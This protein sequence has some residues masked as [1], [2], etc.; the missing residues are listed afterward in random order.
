MNATQLRSKRIVLPSLAAVAALGAGGVAW[1]SAARADLGGGQRDRVA[2]AA[3]R[4]VGGTAVDVESGDDRGEAY[5]VEV[6]RADGSEVDVSLDTN[7][8]V[9]SRHV[10]Q[11]DGDHGDG[12]DEHGD[13]ADEHGDEAGEHGDDGHEGPDAGD[14]AVSAAQRS[15]AERAALASVKGGTVLEVEAGDDPG[16]A[17][18]VEVRDTANKKW[19]LVL[20]SGFTVV[21]TTADD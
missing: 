19:E 5:E 6:R 1:A 4:A 2:A 20:D 12:A 16:E 15:S 13:E 21:R 14:R 3:T 10:D 17:Y 11:H 18:E 7:L 8:H 9:V